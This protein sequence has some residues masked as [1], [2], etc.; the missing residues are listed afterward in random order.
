MIALVLAWVLLPQEVSEQE[1]NNELDKARQEIA[2]GAT[3]TGSL[4]PEGDQDWVH[5]ACEKD[6]LCSIVLE[7]S[8]EE[9]AL[10]EIHFPGTTLTTFPGDRPIRALRVRF[11]KGRTA[12]RIIGRARQ[13]RCRITVVEQGEFKE[14]EPNERIEDA[15]EIREGQTWWGQ[16]S[17]F[18]NDI[19]SYVFKAAS[20]GPREIVLK[21]GPRKERPFRGYIGVFGSDPL[22]VA[23]YYIND[24]ADEFHFYPVLET[25]TWNLQ[26]TILSDTPVG[27][28]YELTLKPP[29]GKVTAEERKAAQGAIDRATRFL[30]NV[31]GDP[32]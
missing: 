31:P 23:Y 20:A 9:T 1:P 12:L 21:C 4:D 27:A 32:P 17:G 30:L 15:H 29:A 24:F 18:Q 16:N 13:Y 5:V 26:L 7:I 22:K 3:F 28:E 6:S 14:V 2:P 11:P 8:K 25:G 19:D 10:L